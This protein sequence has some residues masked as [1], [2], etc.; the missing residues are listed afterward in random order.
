MFFCNLE[1]LPGRIAAIVLTMQVRGGRRS[2]ESWLARHNRDEA[3]RRDFRVSLL[4]CDGQ[5]TTSATFASDG[6]TF[7][8]VDG[9]ESPSWRRSLGRA[10]FLLFGLVRRWNITYRSVVL[11]FRSQFVSEAV[12][13]FCRFVAYFF[14]TFHYGGHR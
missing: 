13:S 7:G 12:R 11:C 10:A 9:R 2:V 1:M 4:V 3:G 8:F 5:Q 14:E 6:S